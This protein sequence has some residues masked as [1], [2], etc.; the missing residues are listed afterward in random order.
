M[1]HKIIIWMGTSHTHTHTHNSVTSDWP[2]HIEGFSVFLIVKTVKK[3]WVQWLLQVWS[4]PEASLWDPQKLLL[5]FGHFTKSS[6]TEKAFVVASDRKWCSTM[7][8]TSRFEGQILNRKKPNNPTRCLSLNDIIQQLKIGFKAHS[9]HSVLSFL[10]VLRCQSFN[11]CWM[12]HYI[13]Q[14]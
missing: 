10:W 6:E 1:V 7:K 3:D 9:Q 5:G 2:A 13:V 14:F 4:M 8:H 11:N 12:W